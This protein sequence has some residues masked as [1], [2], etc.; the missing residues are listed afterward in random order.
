METHEGMETEFLYKVYEE[1]TDQEFFP[2]GMDEFTFSSAPVFITTE[3]MKREAGTVENVVR[4]V[5][6]A[7]ERAK[8]QEEEDGRGDVGRG[9]AG[10][11]EETGRVVTTGSETVKKKRG[12]PRKNV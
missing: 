11:G 3:Y 7:Y 8:S 6:E 10:M 9:S 4:S 5:I 2:I 1:L 12:R